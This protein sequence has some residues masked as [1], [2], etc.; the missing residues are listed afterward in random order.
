ERHAPKGGLI[1]TLFRRRR[2]SARKCS[3]Q[4]IGIYVARSGSMYPN[5]SKMLILTIGLLN[6]CMAVVNGSVDPGAD[7][8]TGAV[9]PKLEGPNLTFS[10]SLIDASHRYQPG[11]MYGGWGAHLG[12]L[13]RSS[14]NELWF[15]DDSG[16]DVHVN[17]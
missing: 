12:H 6:G 4:V 15:V 17:A 13:L 8:M 1:H 2:L 14:G 9:D 3:V 11:A 5:A 10:S 16:N 7:D